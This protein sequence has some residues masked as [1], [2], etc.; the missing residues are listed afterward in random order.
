MLDEV[1]PVPG[2]T[3]DN[4]TR[5]AGLESD[6]RRLYRGRW[7]LGREDIDWLVLTNDAQERQGRRGEEDGGVAPAMSGGC[8]QGE[9][10]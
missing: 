1:A 8:H 3:T 2:V 4:G 5:A 10:R 6:G 9:G 7:R